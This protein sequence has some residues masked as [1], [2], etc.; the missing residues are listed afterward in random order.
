MTDQQPTVA[1]SAAFPAPP[2][3]YK[4]FTNENLARLEKLRASNDSSIEGIS[5]DVPAKVPPALDITSLPTELRYLIPP[6]PPSGEYRSFNTTHGAQPPHSQIFHDAQQLFKAPPLIPL[7]PPTAPSSLPSP[8]RLLT[9]VH[10]ILLEFLALTQI[11]ATEPATYPAKWEDL[12]SVF[13]EAHGIINGY[14]PHQARETLIEMM[15][16]QIRKGRE[17]IKIC[18]EAKTKIKQVLS[19]LGKAD[20]ELEGKGTASVERQA[21]NKR[22]REVSTE[23]EDR[24]V[25]ELLRKEIGTG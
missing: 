9:V 23:E 1:I 11:L 19:G 10:R 13:I 8:Q 25:W 15:E 20:R 6:S 18:D 17:E 5:P 2:P 21:G 22:K 24:R 3:F 4:H 7:P 12:R 16:E 14:R